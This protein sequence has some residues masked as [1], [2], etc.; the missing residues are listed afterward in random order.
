[1]KN[2]YFFGSSC[3]DGN[4]E[5]SNIL[6]VKGAYLAENC[7]LGIRVPPGFTIPYCAKS[8][9]LK[10]PINFIEKETGQKFTN[11]EEY[12]I[13]LLVSVRPD[14]SSSLSLG[15]IL[16]IGINDD[17]AERLISLGYEE[18]FV[19]GAY[20]QLIFSLSLT[21][22]VS[23]DVFEEFHNKNKKSSSFKELCLSFKNIYLNELGV[24]FPQDPQDQ[25]IK[26]ITYFFK[27]CPSLCAVNIQ[28]M[29]FGNIDDNSGSGIANAMIDG[30]HKGE[31]LNKSQVYDITSGMFTSEE[32]DIYKDYGFSCQLFDYLDIITEHY[33]A[34]MYVEFVVEDGE[35]YILK[36]RKLKK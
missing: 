7:S 5:M 36:T 28:Q 11:L 13:P 19:Y 12:D 8:Y 24:E 10:D 2:V 30:G 14:S 16:N 3:V 1:M 27:S 15:A 29:V 35:V 6:G 26:S 31:Y 25:L 17:V 32:F 18:D 33:G 4:F 34:N 23:S 20:S 21:N 9:S 22:G